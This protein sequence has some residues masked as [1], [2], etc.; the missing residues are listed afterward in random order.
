MVDMEETSPERLSIGAFAR[1]VGL[2]ASALRFYD[3]CDL[4]PPTGVD[5]ATGYRFYSRGSR[6]RATLIRRL[7]EIDLPLAEVR[8]IVDGSAD[9]ARTILTDHL[10]VLRTKADLAHARVEDILGDLTALGGASSAFEPAPARVGGPEFASAVRQVLPSTVD[11]LE[12]PVLGCV[13]VEFAGGELRLV[14]TDRYRL[15][16]RTLPIPGS[17]GLAGR[18]VVPAGDLESVA[19]WANR[20]SAVTLVFDNGGL[21]FSSVGESRVVGGDQE[22]PAYE[23]VLA[24]LE[25]AP[26]RLIVDRLALIRLFSSDAGAGPLRLR[27]GE[28]VLIVRTSDGTES[29]LSAIVNGPVGSSFPVLGFDPA[30]LVPVLESSVGPDILLDIAAPDQPVIVRSAD[31]G[32]FTTL[33]M[34]VHPD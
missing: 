11:S 10:V 34:P 12:H 4:L 30:R 21:T 24:G 26:Y 20:K 29:R 14:A 13:L 16:V 25:P 28:D 8:R 5:P 27:T 1:L 22:F 23:I 7:R 18:V 6:A 33:I 31:Q 32:S 15:T 2:S 3:D 19:S 9:Q 17:S